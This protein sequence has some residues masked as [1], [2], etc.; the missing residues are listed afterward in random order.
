MRRVRPGRGAMVLGAAA[1]LASACVT[2]PTGRPQLI[3]V[4]E[5]QMRE[6]GVASFE[7]LKQQRPLSGDAATNAYVRCVAH[8]ITAVLGPGEHRGAWE[9][10][11]FEDQSANAF[12]L[13]GGKIGVHTGL[14]QLAEGQ[15]QLATVIGHEIGHVVARHSAERVS[16]SRAAE[17]LSS[18]VA[19]AGI[20]DPATAIGKVTFTALGLGV[21]YGVIKPYGRSQESEAD[22]IGLDFMARAGFDPAQ[23]IELWRNMAAAVG[24]AEPSEFLSTHPSHDTRIA[25][26]TRRLPRAKKIQQ[27]ARAAGRRPSCRP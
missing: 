17:L 2:S 23:S 26:L 13:P 21:E 9:V 11:V 20:V 15:D 4:S 19:A 7:Q 6:L 24:G 16:Q 10:V 12:A 25:D 1:T 18:G 3:V 8:A 14:L 22:R 27:Q 5:Q